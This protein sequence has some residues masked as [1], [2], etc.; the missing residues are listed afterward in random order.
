MR[1]RDAEV[2]EQLRRADATIQLEWHRRGAERQRLR[3]GR[4]RQLE[5]RRGDRGN[6]VEATGPKV[7][8]LVRG[9][10]RAVLDLNVQRR[11]LAREREH[12]ALG[13]GRRDI[14]AR[15]IRRELDLHEVSGGVGGM[16]VDRPRRRIAVG[17]AS[18]EVIDRW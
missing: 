9:I 6:R 12:F 10:A 14:E 1:G 18:V 15:A 4:E 3:A 2:A 8:E 11:P 17:L 13:G 7:D 16:A 5:A